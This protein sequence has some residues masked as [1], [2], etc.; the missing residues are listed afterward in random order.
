MHKGSWEPPEWVG[1]NY[2]KLMGSHIS[3]S[4]KQLEIHSSAP[5]TELHKILHPT[6]KEHEAGLLPSCSSN[7]TNSME[8]GLESWDLL[9]DK[10]RCHERSRLKVHEGTKSRQKRACCRMRNSHLGPLELHLSKRVWKT[11]ETELKT[12]RSEW[13]FLDLEMVQPS[14]SS[15]I[16]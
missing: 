12:W 4:H 5:P 7:S 3:V 16:K 11:V 10:Q 6:P 13:V 2:G 9:W 14:L 1:C 15:P 8:W